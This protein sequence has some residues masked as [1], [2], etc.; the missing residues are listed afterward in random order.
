MYRSKRGYEIN[1]DEDISQ[2]LLDHEDN[3]NS[4]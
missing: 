3:N 1:K 2:N 4:L